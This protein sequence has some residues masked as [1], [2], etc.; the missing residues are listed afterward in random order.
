MRLDA[1]RLRYRN[2]RINP[3][4]SGPLG[5]GDQL[6]EIIV[7]ARRTRDCT[8]PDKACRL[9]QCEL[10]GALTSIAAEANHGCGAGDHDLL[11]DMAFV[12]DGAH[13]VWCDPQ[14]V[15]AGW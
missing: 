12:A 13:L 1:F 2:C 5:P 3:E 6:L 11:T 4:D 9:A 10:N 7:A 15:S 14:S 8:E